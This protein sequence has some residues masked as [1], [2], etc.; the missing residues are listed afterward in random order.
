MLFCY[1][2]NIN[3]F[4]Y[5]TNYNQQ[6]ISQFGLDILVKVIVVDVHGDMTW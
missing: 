2:F 4:I 1:L 6:N 5:E 3:R